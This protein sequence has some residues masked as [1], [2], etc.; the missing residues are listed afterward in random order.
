MRGLL[1]LS[2]A[3]ILLLL[4]WPGAALAQSSDWRERR[5]ERFAILYDAGDQATADRYAGFVDTIYDEISA[6]FGHQ[7]KTP[8][9]LRLYPSLERYQAVNPL[10]RSMSGIVAHADYHGRWLAPVPAPH[11]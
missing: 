6:I 9:T 10:A 3:L 4:L 7:T 5:T 11:H 1:R 2:S 8:V